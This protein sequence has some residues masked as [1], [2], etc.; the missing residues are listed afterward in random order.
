M[1]ASILAA[2]LL[3]FSPQLAQANSLTQPKGKVILSVTGDIQNKNA[4]ET[5]TFD[6]A[7]LEAIPGRHASM[8]TPWTT[9]TTVFDG[10]SLRN[11]LSQVG[12]H[13]KTL[14][15]KAINDYSA[16]VPMED[17]QSYETILATRMNGTELSVRDKGPLFLIY[18]FDIN[19]ELYNEKYFSRSVWQITEIEVID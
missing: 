15:I 10:P 2:M 6:L 5:A 17:A 4:G 12:A 8:Q 19:P 9:G 18:P 1:K 13:G 3:L 14:R 7:M 11:I 16:D